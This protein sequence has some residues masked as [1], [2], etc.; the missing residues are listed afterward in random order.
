MKKE[1]H[2]LKTKT[3]PVIEALAELSAVKGIVCFGSYALGSF[4]QYSDVDLY[5][6]CQTAIV[7]TAARRDALQKIEG[8]S[9]VQMDHAEFGWDN[10]W[11]HQG[12]RFRLQG[13]LFDITFNTVDWIRTVVRKVTGEGAVST[14]ELR[15]R[16]STML[17][18]L[19]NSIT[20]YDP[21]AVLQKIKF[22]LYPYPRKLKEALVEQSLSTINGSIEDL[23]DYVKRDIGNTAFHFHLQ[24]ITDSL[25]TLL[26]ALNERY[27]PATK[28]VEEAYSKLKIR[29]D[30]FMR[31]YKELLETP[32]TADG[33]RKIARE[34]QALADEMEMLVNSRDS[35]YEPTQRG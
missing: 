15:F 10:Q 31:R 4:D 17:G 24:R 35:A 9:D 25:G 30:N 34:L 3:A 8:I 32:L 26:F 29:P 33:R 16:P 6:F 22:A 27:D 14:P 19:E 1:K 23:R 5:A 12:D 28:R 13:V 2:P 20:L 11:N 18:L 21:E 7:P